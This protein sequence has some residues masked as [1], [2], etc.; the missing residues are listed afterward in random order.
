MDD[1]E[2]IVER[3]VRIAGGANF[4][5]QQLKIKKTW[6]VYKWIK[7]NRIP[8][9]RVIPMEKLSGISR[10]H[11]DPILYPRDRNYFKT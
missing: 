8:P 2:P 10:H 7:E 5:A 9:Y 3:A 6:A 11:L 4:V 1:N